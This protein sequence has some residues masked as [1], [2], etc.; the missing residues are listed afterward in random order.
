MAIDYRSYPIL[1]VDDEAQN[2]VAFR[3]A[4]EDEF[5]VLTAG[6]GQ[7]ALELLR[8]HD[9][10]VMMT[11]Q[12]MPEMTGVELCAHASEEYPDVVRI[13]VTA[14]AD[15][16]A[17][18]DAINEGQV[19]RY[20]V[21]PWRNDELSEVLQTAV[22][23]VH[24]QRTMRDMELRLLHGGQAQVAQVVRDEFIHELTN[25]LG[26]LN[27][28]L[29]HAMESLLSANAQLAAGSEDLDRLRKTLNDAVTSQRDALEVVGEMN[30]MAARLRRGE[31]HARRGAS[32]DAA[33]VVDATVRILRPELERV[34]DV[35]L[36]LEQAP[37]VRLDASALGRA[38]LNLLLNAVQAIESL[39]GQPHRITAWVGCAGGEG[40][41]RVT[42][43]GGGV[44]DGDHVKIFEPYFTT[45]DGGT[46]LGL[47]VVRETVEDVGGQIAVRNGPEGGAVFE[48]RLPIA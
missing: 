6:G 21:K 38:V 48:I 17:A 41:I 2:L 26:A 7:E 3:Y 36:V 1:F 33:R 13:I 28:T 11:D 34:A 24:V 20:V 4:M 8:K 40:L 32:C 35:D 44:D 42:D 37:S 31:R 39:P 9:V 45:K 46:G 25:P 16:H 22:E 19:S 29:E 27:L 5:E 47:S 10:A 30:E 12:R 18:I 14:Y 23:L 43:T 15:I